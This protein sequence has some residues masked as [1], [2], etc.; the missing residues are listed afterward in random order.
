MSKRCDMTCCLCLSQHVDKEAAAS[1]HASAAAKILVQEE[2]NKIVSKLH[3]ILDPFVLRRLKSDVV[4]EL[5]AKHV[6]VLFAS[7]TPAQL[8]L[9]KAIKERR[10]EEMYRTL[11]E[12]EEAHAVAGETMTK[13]KPGSSSLNNLMMQAR[14]N[15]NL[16]AP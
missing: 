8:R 10:V 2:E 3:A 16:M 1:K 7:L 6:Y 4:T 9:N 15:C 5:A 12:E 11:E 13:T 14:N